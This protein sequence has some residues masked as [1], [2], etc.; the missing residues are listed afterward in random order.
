MKKIIAK[1]KAF[2]YARR[3]MKSIREAQDIHSGKRMAITLDEFL[4]EF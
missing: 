4:K 1:I 2:F 3:V